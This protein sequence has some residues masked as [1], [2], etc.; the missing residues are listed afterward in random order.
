MLSKH[1]RPTTQVNDIFG[2][3]STGSHTHWVN[4]CP[5]NLA[6]FHNCAARLLTPRHPLRISASRRPGRR[7][8]S[9]GGHTGTSSLRGFRLARPRSHHHV[10]M[11]KRDDAAADGVISSSEDQ[12]GASMDEDTRQMEARLSQLRLTPQPD[13]LLP[14]L[15]LEGVAEHILSGRACDIVCMVGAGI[16]VS[17]GIPDFRTPGTGLYDNL[18]KYDLPYPEAVFEIGFF[19]RN[20]QP[21]VDL[22]LALFPGKFAPTPAHFFMRL[23]HE[24]GLLRRCYTQNIDSL[25]REAGL[26]ANKIVAAHGNFDSAHCIRCRREHSTE[27]VRE[28]LEK[29]EIS[30]CQ[31]PTC[32]K[33]VKPDIV[34]FGED[35]PR[36]FFQLRATDLPAADL[37]ITMGTSL[38]VHPFA[39]LTALVEDECPRLLI[40]REP[41]GLNLGY[42]FHRKDNRRDVLCLGD[43]DVGVRKL[44]RLLGW[45]A[46]LDALIASHV[47]SLRPSGA[48]GNPEIPATAHIEG[49]TKMASAKSKFEPDIASFRDQ[50]V[51]T[52]ETVAASAG[53]SALGAQA[54]SKPSMAVAQRACEE[55]NDMASKVTPAT[56]DVL[57]KAAPRTAVPEPANNVKKGSANE[58]TAATI[59]KRGGVTAGARHPGGGVK[60]GAQSAVTTM[61]TEANGRVSEAAGDSASAPQDQGTANGC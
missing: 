6:Q 60:G 11:V 12:D 47:P 30:R 51:G 19:K 14:S 24:R 41:A 5:D 46:D 15:D 3:L 17:A 29:R 21:F 61:E 57:S 20:P 44:A 26:P 37:L 35:L 1:C 52:A 55:T 59:C 42:R 50:K 9:K 8:P 31:T 56:S 4:H 13:L 58:M 16:S 23:L 36:R 10:L 32:R 27:Y 33:L 39:G 25:E 7:S 43:A 28:A 38:V 45:E 18:Q 34:F 54:T 53:G 48:Q 49:A 40:N 2:G 22:A